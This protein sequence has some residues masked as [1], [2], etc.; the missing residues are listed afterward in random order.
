MPEIPADKQ[1]ESLEYLH[2]VKGRTGPYSAATGT[3][4]GPPGMMRRPGLR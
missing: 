3:K 1:L 2:A 4:T